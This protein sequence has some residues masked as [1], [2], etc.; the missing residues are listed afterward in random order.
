MRLILLSDK[1]YDEYSS[2]PELLQK[3]TRPYI[4]LEIKIDTQTYAIP[5]RHH[6]SHKYAF[7]TREG[8]GLDYTKAVIIHDESYISSDRPRIEQREFNVIKGKEAKIIKGMT[9]YINLYKKASEHSDNP[10]YENIRRYST[11]KYFL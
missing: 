4:C 9:D 2:M 10:H 5:F 1:F 6:I 7:F 8:C 3:R 11:L